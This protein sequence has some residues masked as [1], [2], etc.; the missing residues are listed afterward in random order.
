MGPLLR[1]RCVQHGREVVERTGA[2]LLERRRS[3]QRLPE[4]HVLEAQG[5][6]LHAI[7]VGAPCGVLLRP[8]CPPEVEAKAKTAV[9][10]CERAATHEQS[11]EGK[12]WR[13]VLIPHDAVT[14]NAT[15]KALVDRYGRTASVSV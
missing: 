5:C 2:K 3:V 15:L 4:L 9:A 8:I 13:Y 12:P 11:I 14:G 10:W 6:E 7:L 1:E